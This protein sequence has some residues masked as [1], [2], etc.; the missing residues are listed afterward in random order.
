MGVV[1]SGARG[2]LP[3]PMPTGGSARGAP[4]CLAGAALRRSMSPRPGPGAESAAAAP[5]LGRA[6]RSMSQ[7][8]RRTSTP[9]YRARSD[10]WSVIGDDHG[11]RPLGVAP[12]THELHDRG[13]GVE[14][15]GVLHL[16]ARHDLLSTSDAR[17]RAS[18]RASAAPGPR[19]AATPCSRGSSQW[20]PASSRMPRTR[21][22]RLSPSMTSSSRSG[23]GGC[24][25]VVAGTAHGRAVRAATI[26]GAVAGRSGWCR[27]PR[28]RA[29][30]GHAGAAHG[31]RGGGRRGG[32]RDQQLAMA[33]DGVSGPASFHGRAG[34]R[35]PR[36]VGG[37]R[38]GARPRG[39][40]AAAAHHDRCWV[41]RGSPGR[42]GTRGCGPWRRVPQGSRPTPM[43]VAVGVDFA[44]TYRRLSIAAEVVRR[45]ALFVATN[46][47]PVYPTADTLA[48]GAGSI[49]AAVVVAGRSRAGPRHRQAGAQVV[50]RSGP[51]DGH[52]RS[53]RPS[54]S[55]TV[56]APTSR[57]RTRVGARSVLMLTGVSTRAHAE[58]LVG[59]GS[60]DLD[61]RGPG[62]AAAAPGALE[63][64]SVAE[65][66]PGSDSRPASGLC[67][68]QRA[69]RRR[70]RRTGRGGWRA[71]ARRGGGTRPRARDGRSPRAPGRLEADGVERVAVLP[72][73]R[74]VA[75]GAVVR[76]QR[77]GHAGAMQLGQRM[78]GDGRARWPPGRCSSGTGP[79]SRRRS[80][81]SAISAGSS[82]GRGAVGDACAAPSSSARRTCADT[83]PFAGVT[84]DAQAGIA[85]DRVGGARS[86]SGRGRRPRGRRSRSPVRPSPGSRPRPRAM[87]GLV[88][89]LECPQR[90]RD[91]PDHD[92][93]PPLPR[94]A[95]PA[96][97]AAMPS[98]R[99]R[100]RR[101]CRDGAQRIS[102]YTRAVGRHILHQ[103]VGD[104]LQRLRRPASAGWA[105]RTPAAGRA[106]RD[107]A[108]APGA[109]RA[110]PHRSVSVRRGRAPAPAPARSRARRL[111]SRWRWSSALGIR[112]MRSRVGVSR[113]MGSG[114]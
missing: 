63:R 109:G 96:T 113:G 42:S 54:S 9:A 74:Q 94:I 56:W 70:R 60:T 73:E 34:R 64:V 79:A 4:A 58:A 33:S 102:A 29:R 7:S 19:A 107:R 78:V 37:A 68:E 20:M 50:P 65:L 48:A 89:R 18:H 57:P 106:G 16:D 3:P 77:H 45:G 59:R 105:G 40:P 31:A 104:P 21:W 39:A 24:C 114:W 10:S 84:G 23:T 97:T 43:R 67:A 35:G 100:P 95:A 49:V 27:L 11:P 103:L 52:A 51:V 15:T 17:D 2:G 86:A 22:S 26:G 87:R 13:V 53:R 108:S 90:D 25:A 75:D 69:R 62:R 88:V 81:S 93:G 14:A 30:A 101:T 32:L 8:R 1:A 41:A 76:G 99:E 46:R 85:G 91:E 72:D 38:D 71:V 83:T 5:G 82:D 66:R 92:T 55:A 6:S 98:R 110:S 44:L 47:D 12:G 61:R 111:P 28:T 112:L 36:R 80:M